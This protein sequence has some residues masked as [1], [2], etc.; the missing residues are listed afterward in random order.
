MG[1]V[2][3]ESPQPN[4][5]SGNCER[6]WTNN[7]DMRLLMLRTATLCMGYILSLALF[8]AAYSFIPV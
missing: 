3:L 2:A 5:R 1:G 4:G 8:A 6:G 7:N